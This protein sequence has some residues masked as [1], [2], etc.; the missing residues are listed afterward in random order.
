MFCLLL[1]CL[2]K[3]FTQRDI[4]ITCEM[5]EVCLFMCNILNFQNTSFPHSW[6]HAEIMYVAS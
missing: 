3:S 5:N 4:S 1:Y 6:K 2:I